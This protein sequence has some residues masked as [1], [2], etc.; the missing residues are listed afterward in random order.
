VGDTS[1]KRTGSAQR[2]PAARAPD[3]HGPAQGRHLSF[4]KKARGL[5]AKP[6]QAR[7]TLVASGLTDADLAKLMAR[8]FRIQARTKRSLIPLTIRLQPPHGLSLN[9]ARRAVRKI[10]S[11][12]AVDFNG[13]YYTDGETPEVLATETP[14]K[15][16]HAP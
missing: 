10:N 3:L 7:S 1:S 12:A 11:N 15:S 16:I 13:Y 14:E 6:Q 2:H 9:Q 8:G 5:G 4:D